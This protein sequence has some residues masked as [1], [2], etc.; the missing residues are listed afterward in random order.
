VARRKLRRALTSKEAE[1]ERRIELV[2]AERLRFLRECERSAR[3][4]QAV[5]QRCRDDPAYFVRHLLWSYD[6]R[7]AKIGLNPRTPFLPFDEQVV[8]FLAI[9]AGYNLANDK[10]RD[11]GASYTA[12]G[13]VLHSFILQPG[14]S[15]GLSSKTGGEAADGTVHSLMGKVQYMHRHLPRFMR[16][17]PEAYSERTR[18]NGYMHNQ[19]NGA[20]VLAKKTTPDAWH[21]AR[22]SGIVFDEIARTPHAGRMVNGARGTTNQTVLITTPAGSYGWWPDLIR[23]ETDEH[24]QELDVKA[25]LDG[26]EPLAGYHHYSL[27]WSMDPRYDDEWARKQR[28]NMSSTEWAINYGISYVASTPGLIFR[29]FSK[30][31]VMTQHQWDLFVGAVLSSC[32]IY[33]A[34]DPGLFAS[35]VWIAHVKDD[36]AGVDELVVCDYLS[37]H[38]RGV[39][40]MVREMGS[41]ERDWAPD[42]IRTGA[43]P[44]GLLPAVRTGDPAVNQRN[45][46]TLRTWR[47]EL[48]DLGVDV[49][50]APGLKGE[51][52]KLRIRVKKE[53]EKKTL[54][55]SP[56][57]LRK[58]DDS[59]DKGRRLPSLVDAMGQYRLHLK[60][61]DNAPE[62][63][64]GPESHICEALQYDI[65]AIRDDSGAGL[66]VM[67]NGRMVLDD[68]REDTDPSR[69]RWDD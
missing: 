59:D 19:L 8:F 27:H 57:C 25:V 64:K 13:G 36:D 17:P 39:T 68:G 10:S 21:S 40:G 41:I 45:S 52:E 30:R 18:P 48:S 3:L 55:F 49:T 50:P 26:L 14:S 15:W 37:Q 47:D 12:C 31:M 61:G 56:H 1:W 32:R 66:Y 28:A 53:L 23:G 51:T 63:V 65:A 24:I 44:G 11:T 58:P 34:C 16:V 7:R 4:R 42:G 67:R 43:N 62:P 33:E 20:D 6:Q 46:A 2:S 35:V 69:D 54:W 60:P 5:W 22:C 29:E 9:I 38:G